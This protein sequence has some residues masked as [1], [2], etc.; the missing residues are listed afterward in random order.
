MSRNSVN[1]AQ[2]SAM[3]YSISETAKLSNLKTHY[4]PRDMLTELP[5]LYDEI[6]NMD[7]AKPDHLLPW[8]K[9][10]PGGYRKPHCRKP[11]DN[12]TLTFQMTLIWTCTLTAD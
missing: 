2:A 8:A 5:K 12:L 4:Y 1:G 9:E 11:A 10:L 7:P 3:I 6:E